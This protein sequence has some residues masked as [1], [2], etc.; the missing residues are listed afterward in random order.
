MPIEMQYWNITNLLPRSSSRQ[1][2]SPVMSSIPMIFIRLAFLAT[3]ASPPPAPGR[4]TGATGCDPRAAPGRP[5]LWLGRCA[6]NRAA[7]PAPGAS[8]RDTAGAPRQSPGVSRGECLAGLSDVSDAVSGAL[9]DVVGY[10]KGVSH[11]H[12][13]PLIGSEG[14]PRRT[15]GR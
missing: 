11:G 8:D 6:G 9:S 1:R 5:C 14:P 13:A 15:P 7:G 10:E 12:R 4:A 3:R 2:S